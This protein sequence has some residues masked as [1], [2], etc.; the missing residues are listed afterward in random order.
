MLKIKVNNSIIHRSIFSNY[1][2]IY[3]FRSFNFK[4]N[5]GMKNSFYLFDFVIR[6]RTSYVK[7]LTSNLKKKKG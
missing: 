4:L 7:E 5:L 6:K 2:Y 3:I 1:I